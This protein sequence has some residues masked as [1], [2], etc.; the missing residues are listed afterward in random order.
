MAGNGHF[1]Y[2]MNINSL[3]AAVLKG[4]NCAEKQLFETLTDN[5]LMFVQH[6]I[7][8]KQDAQEIVQDTMTTIA[9]KYG[10]VEFEISFAAWAYRILQNKILHYYRTKKYEANRFAP[11]SERESVTPDGAIDPQLRIKLLD[12]LRQISALNLR[13]ARI[14]NLSYQGYDVAEICDRLSLTP[15]NC[16]KLL[17]RARTALRKCLGIG[18][19]QQ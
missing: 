9:G 10:G 4:E 18:D 16:Y 15:G 12:C 2:K 13:H 8:N 1:L 11:E 14:L 5:F 7:W 6:K 17:S 19:E 3:H